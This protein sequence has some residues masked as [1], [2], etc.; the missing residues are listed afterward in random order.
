MSVMYKLENQDNNFAGIIRLITL[1]LLEESRA[2]SQSYFQAIS[3]VNTFCVK[4]FLEQEHIKTHLSKVIKTFFL[5]L[6]LLS[7]NHT[8]FCVIFFKLRV[9]K[10]YQFSA[11]YY[12]TL[13]GKLE[14]IP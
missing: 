1:L 14:T 9:V 7:L 6:C 12:C 13:T 4:Q 2:G 10:L 3:T 5:K 11:D 8:V